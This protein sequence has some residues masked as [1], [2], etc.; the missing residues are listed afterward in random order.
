V[1][2]R[3]LFLPP[4]SSI[5]ALAWRLTAFILPLAGVAQAAYRSTFRGIGISLVLAFWA[6]RKATAYSKPDA[7]R[8][9]RIDPRPP[10]LLLRAFQDDLA[11]VGFRGKRLEQVLVKL[12]ARLGPP[13]AIGDPK[14][15]IPKLGAFR[16][17]CPGDNNDWQVV[18][19]AWMKESRMIMLFA[20][21]TDN[22]MW[23]VEQIG[24]LDLFSKTI[25]FFPSTKKQDRK[26]RW[27][28]IR[29]QL[30]RIYD[31]ELLGHIQ[32][33]VLTAIAHTPSGK[34]VFIMSGSI[35]Q[36]DFEI[37]ARIAVVVGATV[38]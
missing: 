17:Y 5:K 35:E 16:T 1:N 24:Q 19:K 28:W 29:F 25:L 7:Q 11:T 10:V 4:H 21:Y 3:Q 32:P 20:G 27:E 37:S 36:A 38:G 14:E 12:A 30:H 6:F 34:P 15:T 13:V 22:L 23:E 26:K 2:I 18:A 8:V 31:A 9:L 33:D